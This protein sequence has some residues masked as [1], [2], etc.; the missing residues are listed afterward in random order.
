[1]KR[2]LIGVS[3]AL[4]WCAGGARPEDA[5]PTDGW[6]VEAK[7]NPIDDTAS[8]VFASVLGDSYRG[9]PLRLL[10]RYMADETDVLTAIQ[11]SVFMPFS[12]YIGGNIQTKVRFDKETATS[13]GGNASTDGNAYFLAN[14]ISFVKQLA[15]AKEL[16]IEVTTSKGQFI[17]TFNVT[18]FR[19]IAERISAAC[20]WELPPPQTAAQ[21]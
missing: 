19:P 3:L 20:H 18:G 12:E 9:E 15:D 6:E 8:E 1:M 2:A 14:A 21:G 5:A 10:A 17:S 16:A 13:V 4:M 7:T 11:G